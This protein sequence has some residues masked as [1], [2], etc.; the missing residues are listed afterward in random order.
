MQK[1]YFNI[2]RPS[3]TALTMIVGV[4]PLRYQHHMTECHN[5]HKHSQSF[6]YCNIYQYFSALNLTVLRIQVNWLKSRIQ[7]NWLKSRIQANWLE[8]KKS[9]NVSYIKL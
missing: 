6:D 1:R 9:T 7:V 3:Q 5:F 2:R 4:V 8:F